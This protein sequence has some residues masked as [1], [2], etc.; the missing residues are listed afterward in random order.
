MKPTV[1]RIVHFRTYSNDEV[2][3]AIIT[4]VHNDTCV[5]LR[6]FSDS[7]PHNDEFRI[8]V[9]QGD[10]RGQWNW[11]P[12]TEEKPAPAQVPNPAVIPGTVIKQ[13]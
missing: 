1:G 11:P 10:S 12:R 3:P 2:E 5:N 7:Q 4:K 8:S 6:I 13:G 9:T